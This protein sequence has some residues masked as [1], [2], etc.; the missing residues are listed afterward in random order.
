MGMLSRIIISAT[1]LIL[2]L[3][4]W[5]TSPLTPHTAEYQVN[6]GNIELG[7]A[8]YK[9]PPSD[10]DQFTYQ[11]DSALSLLMLTDV[12]QIRSEFSLVDGQLVP[13][14]YSQQRDGTGPS[15]N[16]QSAFA[17]TQGVVHT[18]YKDEKGK[19]PYEGVLFDPLMVQLQFRL[20]LSAGKEPLHYKMV[21]DNEIDE[22]DFKIVGNE[23]LTIESGSYETV[24]IEVIRSSKKRQTFFWMAPDLSY[25]PVRLTHFE[26]GDK[27]LDIK[28]LNYHFY[29]TE[30]TMPDSSTM[31]EPNSIKPPV[32]DKQAAELASELQKTLTES[33]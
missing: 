33:K 5:A 28:L 7:K 13:M 10:N 26:K 32:D 3:P 20:D 24:K 4:V 12:R 15:F 30:T 2:T 29:D 1:G 8:R 9:L 21:K 31:T 22:Y 27:Q 19:L 23:R 17:K 11:F 14:R 16:E 25:L 6:Y 18:R